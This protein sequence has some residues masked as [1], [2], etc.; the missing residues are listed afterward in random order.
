MQTAQIRHT[1][2]TV[3][4][5]YDEDANLWRFTLR[6]RDRSASSL[7][8][9]R[10]AI[11]KPEPKK[12]KPFEKIKAWECRYGD[13]PSRVEVTGIAEGRGYAGE[14]D[15]FVWITDAQRRRRKESVKLHIFPSNAK[16]D[17]IAE[18]ITARRKEMAKLDDECAK[19][20]RTFEPLVIAPEE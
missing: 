1:H 12:S 8:L 4:I 20:A 11:D 7:T 19:L 5:T 6:G 17:A 2:K 15:S 18:Q 9:A 10:E 13:M 16:N 14:G 3:V